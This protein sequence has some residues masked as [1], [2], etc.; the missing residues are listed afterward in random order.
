M[1]ANEILLSLIAGKKLAIYRA[2][3]N[4]LTITKKNDL[5]HF[6]VVVNEKEFTFKYSKKHK[7][8][9]YIKK[10]IGEWK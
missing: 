9:N 10:W 2:N 1:E 3:G 4:L 7:V 6:I 8:L 5:F